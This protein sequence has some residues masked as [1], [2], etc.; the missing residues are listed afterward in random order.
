ME[1]SLLAE[2]TCEGLLAGLQTLL[3]FFGLLLDDL[4]AH[5]LLGLLVVVRHKLV[6]LLVT[7]SLLREGID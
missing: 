4:L 6:D 5:C 7:V 2:E 1:T 3:L